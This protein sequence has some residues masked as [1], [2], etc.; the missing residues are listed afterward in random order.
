A[1]YDE[2]LDAGLGRADALVALGGGVVGDMTGFVASTYM[3]GIGYV[4]VPTTTLAAVDSSVGG[5]TAVN[6]RRGKNLVGTFY[7]PRA[8][9]IAAAH[10]RTQDRRGH[11]A[12]LCEA[13]KMAACLDAELFAEMESTAAR[14]VSLDPAA[15][16]AIIR[17]AVALKAAVVS[18]DEREMGER[19]VLNYGHTLGH[20]IETGEGYRLLH[21]EA[22]GLGMLAEADWAE[23]EGLATHIS[24]QLMRALLAMNMPCEWRRAKVDVGALGLDK[25]RAGAEVKMPVVRT[26]GS[27]EMHNVPLA[28]LVSYVSHRNDST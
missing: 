5:K 8:V 25:K 13:L 10:L 9:L 7:P 15:T 21:G 23:S 20:A 27:Y 28:K 16:L 1:L 24:G 6:T 19:A 2:L 22:V 18:R 3:R 26:L 4:Q 12:G 11:A 14:L 17:R